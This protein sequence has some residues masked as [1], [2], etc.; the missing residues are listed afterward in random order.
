M[1]QLKNRVIRRPH[2]V[3]GIHCPINFSL[4]QFVNSLRYRCMLIVETQKEALAKK[5]NEVISSAILTSSS[6]WSRR[7]GYTLC[8]VTSLS[9]LL[10]AIVILSDSIPRIFI[11]ISSLKKLIF[12]ILFVWGNSVSIT[13]RIILWNIFLSWFL[14]WLNVI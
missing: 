9:I 3:A 7:V 12:S 1:F 8:K 13:P 6:S 5:L 10:F 2:K 4:K 14:D 11:I